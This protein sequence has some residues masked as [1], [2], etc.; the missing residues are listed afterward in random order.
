MTPTLIDLDRGNAY[1]GKT[2]TAGDGKAYFS[3]GS[4][5][6]FPAGTKFSPENPG[7]GKP[8]LRVMPAKLPSGHQGPSFVLIIG[9]TKTTVLN[10]IRRCELGV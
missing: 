1:D 9:A 4:E 5:A 3:D 10:G 7:D 8:G 6:A 2:Y